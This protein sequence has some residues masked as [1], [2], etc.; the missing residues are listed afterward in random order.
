MPD[1]PIKLFISHASEDKEAFVRRLANGLKKNPNFEVWYDE[2]SLRLGDSLSQSITKG[3]G[4]CDYGIV[5]L[6]PDFFSKKWP[7]NEFGAMLSLETK[8]RKI[9]L[10]IWHNGVTHEQVL[11]FNPILADRIK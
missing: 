5:V 1:R 10:P 6:S 2:Y 4:S 9:L 8:E 3:L 11:E 7:A